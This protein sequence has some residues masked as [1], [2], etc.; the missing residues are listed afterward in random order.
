MFVHFVFFH[1]SSTWGHASSVD[2]MRSSFT[3]ENKNVKNQTE[4]SLIWHFK[5]LVMLE[6]LWYPPIIGIYN[7]HI[8]LP[9]LGIKDAGTLVL[10]QRADS[11][12]A[13]PSLMR[14]S[15]S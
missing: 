14:S 8:F 11:S 15:P 5:T 4:L 13:S 12:T 9:L 7:D 2:R 6:P 10:S 3:L 1:F